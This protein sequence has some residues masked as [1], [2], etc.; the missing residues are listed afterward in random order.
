MTTKNANTSSEAPGIS[1]TEIYM[2]FL[3]NMRERFDGNVGQLT[4]KMANATDPEKIL[5]YQ[6]E[7]KRVQRRVDVLNRLYDG[8]RPVDM[9][10][11]IGN[12]AEPEVKRD[13]QPLFDVI[14]DLREALNL[15]IDDIRAISARE[16]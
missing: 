4:D 8:I 14:A 6:K 11:I 16:V 2:E 10:E 5:A 3:D 9:Q 15:T 12:V 1:M 13:L 7:L